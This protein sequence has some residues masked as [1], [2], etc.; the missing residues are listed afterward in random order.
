[1]SGVSSFLPHVTLLHGHAI[2]AIEE[3]IVP[4]QWHVQIWT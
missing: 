1:M 3:T 4:V 2:D